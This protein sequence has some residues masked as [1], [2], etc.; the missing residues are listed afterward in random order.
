M[1]FLSMKMVVLCF[2]FFQLCRGL[3]PE[4]IDLFSAPNLGSISSSDEDDNG[5][6]SCGGNGGQWRILWN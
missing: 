4:G 5:D 1:N 2:F 6:E 3:G